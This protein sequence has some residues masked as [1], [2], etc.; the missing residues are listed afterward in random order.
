MAK[1]AE[2]FNKEEAMNS[3]YTMIEDEELMTSA[4]SVAEAN[5]QVAAA[6]VEGL[7]LEEA[8]VSGGWSTSNGVKHYN[9]QSLL[10]MDGEW[11]TGPSLAALCRPVL[12]DSYIWMKFGVV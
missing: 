12:G 4:K 11:I 1:K 5:K 9:D 7:M 8:M 2:I 6:G 10:E 3:D